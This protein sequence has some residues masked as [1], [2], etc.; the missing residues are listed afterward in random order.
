MQTF[1]PYSDFKKSALVL[2][3][4]RLGKQ[5]IET[6]QLLQTFS[7]NCNKKGWLNHPARLMW[8]NNL[9]AL[10]YYG[11]IICQEWISRN[12]KDSCLSKILYIISEIRSENLTLEKLEKLSL[13]DNFYPSWF[14]NFDFHN[15]HKSNL[16][17]KNSEH[18]SKFNWNVKDSLSYIWPL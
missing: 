10:S 12:Y 6:M 5:R 17:R 8:Q 11:I 16:L 14:G 4:Q 3:R 7:K 2:D 9:S 1:L 18:Y 13:E 15:S